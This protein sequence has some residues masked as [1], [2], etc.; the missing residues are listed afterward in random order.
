MLYPD[1]G[2]YGF[3]TYDGCPIYISPHGAPQE[4]ASYTL[5][6]F[7]GLFDKNRKEIYEGDL[8]AGF[9]RVSE[10]LEVQW[11]DGGIELHFPKSANAEY[12]RHCAR[13]ASN[14]T[15]ILEI[16]GNIYETKETP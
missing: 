1:A 7:T 9:S 3:M 14:A 10:P 6:Q 5:M 4:M 16:V 13:I 11:F 12:H 15:N 8:L 2:I